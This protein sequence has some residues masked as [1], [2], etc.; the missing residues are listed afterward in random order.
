MQK[1][2]K[3]EEDDWDPNKKY[4]AAQEREIAVEKWVAVGLAA[5][6]GVGWFVWLRYQLIDSLLLKY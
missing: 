5:A 4:F 1:W 3:F 6:A 2:K